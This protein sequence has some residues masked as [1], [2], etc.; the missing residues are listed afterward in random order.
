[1]SEEVQLSCKCGEVRGRLRDPSPKNVSHV[2]CYCEDCQTFAHYLGRADLLDEHGGSDI[3]QVAPGNLTWTQ[4]IEKI[5][6]VRLGPKGPF[7]WH[8]TCCK[9][10]LGNSVTPNIPFIGL[11]HEVLE[12]GTAPFGPPTHKLYAKSAIGKPSGASEKVPVGLMASAAALMIGWKL[13]G[14]AWPN[15]FFERGRAIPR[16]PVTILAKEEREALLKKCG[17]N[18]SVSATPSQGSESAS[19]S[20]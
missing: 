1:M 3:V 9:T 2:I 18:P 13:R 10:P 14:R 12:E 6:A 19:A 5:A 11:V 20:A 4:G 7:R 15:P 8:A 17:P 16:F